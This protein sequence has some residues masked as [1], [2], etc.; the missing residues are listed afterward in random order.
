[1][2]VPVE[3]PATRRLFFA[4]W[5]D[6]PTAG[7]LDRALRALRLG[8]ARRIAPERLHITLAFL[9]IVDETRLPV[10]ER[11][12]SAIAAAPFTLVLDRLEIWR[13]AGVVCL[14]PAQESPELL[15]LVERL[16][17]ALGAS[18]FPCDHRPYRTHLTIARNARR[19][20]IAGPVPPL[21]WPVG[22]YTLVESVLRPEGAAYAVLRR[23]PLTAAVGEALPPTDP[24]G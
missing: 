1:M 3:P 12:G 23:W 18:G 11:A 15:A 2:A 16:R 24:M 5:P 17:E 8:S 13:E 4:L 21:P 7:A 9:G 10:L 22:E 6:A 20:R 19:E 14:C